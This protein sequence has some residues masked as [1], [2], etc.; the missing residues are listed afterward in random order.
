MRMKIAQQ[1]LIIKYLIC[2]LYLIYFR[3]NSDLS[4]KDEGK[5]KNSIFNDFSNKPTQISLEK[6]KKNE[7]IA[8]HF[9]NNHAQKSKDVYLDSNCNNNNSVNDEDYIAEDQ[10]DLSNN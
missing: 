9:S 2:K 10:I 3:N 8:N 5:R 4:Y 6:M 7:N 1:R